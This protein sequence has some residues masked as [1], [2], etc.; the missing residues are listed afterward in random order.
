[1]VPAQFDKYESN[2]LQFMGYI[3]GCTYNIGQ[4]FTKNSLLQLEPIDVYSYLCYRIFGIE[5]PSPEDNPKYWRGS[6]LDYHKKAISYF[7]I[8]KMH[9]WNEENVS[10]NP[11]RSS[12]VNGL[13]EFVAKKQAQ[14]L[15]KQSNV[16]RDLTI[17]EFAQIITILR[18][19]SNPIRKY[20][21]S[22]YLIFQYNMIGRIDDVA[23]VYMENI[24]SSPVY[25]YALMVSVGWSKNVLEE[26]D[27]PDQI[28]VG[29]N[30]PTY[31]VLLALAIHLETWVGGVS[32]HTEFLF[33][34]MSDPEST[35]TRVGDVLRK[36]VFRS[37]SFVPDYDGNLGSHSIRKL[38]S[39]YASNSCNP[40][41]VS[42]RGRWKA[43]KKMV[44][45]YISTTLP[46]PDAKV[47]GALAVGGPVKYTLTEG[48]GISDDWIAKHV[49]PNII[50]VFNRKVSMVLGY[51]LLW[52]CFEPK[53][54]AHLPSFLVDR[55]DSE[56]SYVINLEECENQ[57]KTLCLLLVVMMG[58]LLLMIFVIQYLTILEIM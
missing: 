37:K 11:T 47:A 44:D 21:M 39:T 22:A 15:G 40:H 48:C 12:M 56:Y 42:R 53:I 32:G 9:V 50:R 3:D 13:V 46:Y 30:N 51:A 25:P 5:T 24:K 7:M 35:K 23:H 54:K 18:G 57:V 58:S 31:C 41:E 4:T 38:A 26:R 8:N 34:L 49:V 55:V 16:V 1:M 14:Q 10:G 6:T 33:A 36:E 27:A 28:L 17:T 43:G 45:I 52:G 19:M 29:A 20:S 2:F